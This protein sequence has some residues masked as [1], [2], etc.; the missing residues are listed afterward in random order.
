M[1][2]PSVSW[3]KI[4][5]KLFSWN[6]VCLGQK[7]PIKIQLFRLLSYLIKVH[8]IPHFNFETT[9]S[10][11][12]QILH[13][14]SVLWKITPLYLFSSSLIYFG[15]KKPIELKFSELWVV[16][17]KFA[18]FLMSYLKPKVSFSSLSITLQGH[19]INLL[20]FFSWN[21]KTKRIPSNWEISDFRLLTWN[22]P[23]YLLW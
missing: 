13:H 10:G 12:I 14:C 2:N 18:N 1:H 4:P 20:C 8:P 9:R 3:Y 21:F 22:F 19:E 6:I 23:K 5:L 7:E 16:G 15:Q 11:F 17:W